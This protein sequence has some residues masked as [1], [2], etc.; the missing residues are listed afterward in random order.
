MCDVLEKCHAQLMY[1]TVRNVVLEKGE[2]ATAGSTHVVIGPEYLSSAI[3]ECC[4]PTPFLKD[5]SSISL[6]TCL[7]SFRLSRYFL[8]RSS[9]LRCLSVSPHIR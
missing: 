3:S 8:R 4:S 5:C 7:P 2:A 9:R 1:C 6:S